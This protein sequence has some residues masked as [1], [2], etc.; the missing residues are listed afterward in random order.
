MHILRTFLIFFIFTFT[1]SVSAELSEAQKESIEKNIWEIQG[2]YK[3]DA[4]KEYIMIR[5][6]DTYGITNWKPVHINQVIIDRPHIEG[7]RTTS[8]HIAEPSRNFP[9][10]FT[11][12][13][14]QDLNLG[15]RVII[16]K[17]RKEFNLEKI[18]KAFIERESKKIDRDADIKA[19]C[20]TNCLTDYFR[21]HIR[22][23]PK[24]LESNWIPY[25]LVERLGTA[26]HIGTGER[27][28][29]QEFIIYEQTRSLSVVHYSTI[30]KH[31]IKSEHLIQNINQLSPEH[32]ARTYGMR[33]Y[34]H[35]SKPNE[36]KRVYKLLPQPSA[37]LSPF[38]ISSIT[39]DDEGNTVKEFISE[40]GSRVKI[41]IEGK[42]RSLK[43]LNQDKALEFA[44]KHREDYKN[45][46]HG[47]NFQFIKIPGSTVAISSWSS[48]TYSRKK[49]KQK[50]KNK[51]NI[52]MEAAVFDANQSTYVVVESSSPELLN[53]E[54]EVL[55]LLAS[56]SLEYVAVSLAAY[57]ELEPDVFTWDQYLSATID[58]HGLLR[59]NF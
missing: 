4:N 51:N 42:A 46:K 21:D 33:N 20:D 58:K 54:M 1:L 41:V 47:S 59:T 9:Q 23:T 40:R 39:K 50:H 19:N 53:R 22:I 38:R 35:H 7:F 18:N 30:N 25:V 12:T 52:F 32:A 48:N 26:S 24:S 2:L 37:P 5:P 44:E 27:V 29:F 43:S 28:F 15:S 8:Y 17:V 49:T 45:L 3:N 16:R 11:Q 36:D 56:K 34:T 55:A 57:Y 31:M 10:A 13:T 14:M 6:V